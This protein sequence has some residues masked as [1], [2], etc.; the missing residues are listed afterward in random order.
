MVK[1]ACPYDGDNDIFRR[2]SSAHLPASD[3]ISSDQSVFA[4]QQYFLPVVLFHLARAV[5]D[6]RSRLSQGQNT[7]LTKSKH[8]Q[9]F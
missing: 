9:H 5:T 7:Y 1:S 2:E 4:I 3:G 8:E 6:N